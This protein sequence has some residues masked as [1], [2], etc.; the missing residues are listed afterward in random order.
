MSYP[1]I[2]PL[3]LILGEDTITRFKDNDLSTAICDVLFYGKKEIST[4]KSN[5]KGS[6]TPNLSEY[7][8]NKNN[9]NYHSNRCAL[10]CDEHLG[11]KENKI[12]E[13]HSK[14]ANANFNCINDF[15]FLCQQ[16]YWEM[17][18]S[19]PLTIKAKKEKSLKELIPSFTY[20]EIDEKIKDRDYNIFDQALIIAAYAADGAKAVDKIETASI[21]KEIRKKECVVPDPKAAYIIVIYYR[22]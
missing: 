2:V 7:M 3:L 15:L 13:M 22:F 4:S 21:V 18:Q 17:Q 20:R 5:S 8:Y 11:R 10:L 6:L 14:L 1:L 16:Y 12:A 19:E 9:H